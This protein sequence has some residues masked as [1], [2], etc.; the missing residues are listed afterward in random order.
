MTSVRNCLNEWRV[1]NWFLFNRDLLLK[2]IYFL[3]RSKA[4]TEWR[5]P[6]AGAERGASENVSV[7]DLMVDFNNCEQQLCCS[8]KYGSNKAST[9]VMSLWCSPKCWLLTNLK[10]LFET[11]APAKRHLTD[12]AA[13]NLPEVAAV[14]LG[15]ILTGDLRRRKRGIKCPHL[16]LKNYPRSRPIKSFWW[17]VSSTNIIPVIHEFAI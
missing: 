7:S 12:A 2:S 3:L 8:L 16:F 6:G 14:I 15:S 1:F 17:T 9:I 5:A 4:V 13:V 11:F 10:L